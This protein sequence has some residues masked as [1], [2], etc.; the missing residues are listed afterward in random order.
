MAERG[1]HQRR[2]AR[3]RLRAYTGP[4][5]ETAFRPPS[6]KQ[7]LMAWNEAAGAERCRWREPPVR[8]S[9]LGWPAPDAGRV[10]WKG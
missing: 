10:G 6:A 8:P 2:I 3:P 1:R 7:R 5:H 9:G 4:K